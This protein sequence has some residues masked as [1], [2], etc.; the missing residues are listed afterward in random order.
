LAA[1]EDVGG[2]DE[3]ITIAGRIA[4]GALR[5]AGARMAADA[6]NE[7]EEIVYEREL[8]LNALDEWNGTKKRMKGWSV[9]DVFC[10]HNAFETFVAGL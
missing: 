5:F 2:Q 4:N 7:T 9:Q 8:V 1:D 3:E 6:S 10:C